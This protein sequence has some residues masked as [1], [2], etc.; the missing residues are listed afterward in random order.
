M[1]LIVKA[2]GK[3][4]EDI[5]TMAKDLWKDDYS[6]KEMRN[7][8]EEALTSDMFNVLLYLSENIAAGFIFLSIRTDYVEGSDSSPTGYM[9]GIYVKPD[10]RKSGVAKKLLIEGEKWLKEQGCKQIGSDTYIDNQMSI[11]FHIKSG[12]KEA[13]RLVTF[14]KDI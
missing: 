6:E 12:F 2:T 11:G 14:I 10:F 4:L 9:E 8:F 5:L 13:G 7:F 3:H 1:E